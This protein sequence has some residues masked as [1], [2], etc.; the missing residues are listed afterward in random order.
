MNNKTLSVCIIAKNEEKNIGRCL[1]SIKDLADEIIV[2]DTGSTDKTVE[3]AKSYGAKIGH[4][5]W[6]N[7]FSDARNA[8][9]ELATKDWII[10]LDAD[11]EMPKEEGIRLKQLIN[12]TPLEAF[13]C[14]LVNIIQNTNI[15]DAIVL[16]AFKN[17][18]K[19]RFRGKMHEQVIFSIQEV[20]GEQSIGLTDIKIMHY[21]YDPDIADMDLKQRRN[22][23]LLES[24]D[25]KDKDGYYYYSLGNEYS[26]INE[27]D[28]ALE[29]YYKAYDPNCRSSYMPYLCVNIAKTLFGCK[30]YS[31]EINEIDKFTKLYPDL[32][33]LY[34]LKALAAIECNKFTLAKKSILDYFN[35]D[36]E[37]FVYP[38]S[39]FDSLYNIAELLTKVKKGCVPHEEN[40]L[41]ALILLPTQIDFVI[42]TI[43]S[44]NELCDEV[45][46]VV[47]KTSDVDRI[48]LKNLGVKIIESDSIDQGA[49]FMLGARNCTCKYTLFINPNEIL[50]VE[51]QKLL[52]NSLA[53]K[54]DVKFLN[55]IIID[56]NTK[57]QSSEFRLFKNTD[58]FKQIK[59]F[60]S[61]MSFVEQSNRQQAPIAI[62][63]Y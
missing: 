1:E 49:N 34:F 44:V 33:D 25:E 26:R 43:K 24:Y 3:I 5:K 55:L 23:E 19:Y 27:I 60:N 48:T 56:S 18:P 54:E 37:E 59:F 47:P 38:N 13:H 14:R 50:S 46:V 4:F 8:S 7:N 12:V 21:G 6:N 22:L 31:E 2:V 9:L 16:R 10:F 29:T 39:N 11:E 62:H 17:N 36:I 52:A 57:T 40:F 61:F 58:I 51:S 30:R 32:R 53:Q 45:V 35:S 20:S 41:S 28:K 42:N 15:G 63:R